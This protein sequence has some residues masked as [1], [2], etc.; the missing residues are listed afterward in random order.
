MGR[1]IRLFCTVL[2]A[3]VCTLSSADNRSW[4]KYTVDGSRTG[5]VSPSKDN[6]D[7]AL[8][9]MDKGTYVS[10]SGRKFRKCSATANVASALIEVQPQM[11]RVKEIVGYAPESIYKA[12]PESPLSNMFVDII[13]SSVQDLSGHK[14]DVGIG[15]FGGIRLD[16]IKGD[17]LLDDMLSM[18]PFKN[19]I[20]YVAHKGSTLKNIVGK[21]V[22]SRFQV[23]GGVN[24]VVED[25]KL[26]KFLI[27]GEP[28]EDD[29]VYG[30]ATISFLLNGGDNLFLGK[31][32]L[33]IMTFDVDIIDI[34]LDYVRNLTEAGKPI[35]YS[36]DSRIIIK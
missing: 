6:V 18:F 1:I 9:R 17:I 16:E 31:D 5:C 23:L 21:M 32:A 14:V 24:I 11:A 30:L 4:K 33:E 28:V 26:V 7:E 36:S 29:K 20:V 2:L 12:Y 15:N 10:P 3:L 8:G 27:G 34:M 22:D 13:M 25:G 35:C 19:Q